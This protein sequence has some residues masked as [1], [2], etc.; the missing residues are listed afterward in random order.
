MGTSAT[1]PENDEEIE[2]LLHGY[3]SCCHNAA[4]ELMRNQATRAA[5]RVL[6]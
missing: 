1:G 6:R 4:M 3:T 2:H 5:G